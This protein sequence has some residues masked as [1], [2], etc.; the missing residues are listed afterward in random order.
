[1][2]RFLFALV[3]LVGGPVSAGLISRVCGRGA[4]GRC[5]TCWL[6]RP[7]DPIRLQAPRPHVGQACKHAVLPLLVVLLAGSAA[8]AATASRHRRSLPPFRNHFA[9]PVPITSPKL[10]WRWGGGANEELAEQTGRSIN[11]K[12]AGRGDWLQDR[13][14][15][16]ASDAD[17][18]KAN[19]SD[20]PPGKPQAQFEHYSSAF[21]HHCQEQSRQR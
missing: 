21:Q 9:V 16:K 12:T 20:P 3:L 6:Q 18:R 7:N 14:A 1:M 19:A 10:G 17:Q 8:E 5:E 15:A 11:V 13:A 2:F 4:R